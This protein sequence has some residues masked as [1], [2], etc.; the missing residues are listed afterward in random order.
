MSVPHMDIGVAGVKHDAALKF[1]LGSRAVVVMEQ[2]GPAE[3]GVRLAG[4]FYLQ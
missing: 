3:R 4:L 1:F 2:Q